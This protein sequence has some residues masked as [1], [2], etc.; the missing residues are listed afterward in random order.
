MPRARR[1][2]AK[3]PNDVVRT[4]AAKMLGLA[5]DPRPRQSI[6]MRGAPPRWRLR[7]GRYRIIYT[8]SD[9]DQLVMILKVALRGPHTYD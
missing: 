6:K 7:F 3:L 8:I 1:D 9:R 5:D 4:A 2:L